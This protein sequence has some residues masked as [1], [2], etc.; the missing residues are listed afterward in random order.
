MLA[1]YLTPMLDHPHC[2]TSLFVIVSIG[3]LG[4]ELGC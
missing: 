4:T 1:V 2:Q 3:D